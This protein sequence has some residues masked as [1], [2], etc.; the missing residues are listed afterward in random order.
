MPPETVWLMVGEVE[1]FIPSLRPSRPGEQAEVISHLLLEIRACAR[2][3]QNN[4]FPSVRRGEQHR[5]STNSEQ[6]LLRLTN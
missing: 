5:H 1:G 4:G 6:Q 2:A 3:R